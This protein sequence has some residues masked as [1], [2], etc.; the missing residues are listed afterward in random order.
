MTSPGSTAAQEFYGRWAGLYDL[1]ARRTP[2][3]AGLRRRAAAACRLEAGDT[4]VEMGCGTGANF[5]YIRDAVGPEGAVFGIDLVP[6]MLGEARRRIRKRGWENV[7]VARGD[8]TQ[9]PIGE[10]DAVVSTFLVGMLADPAS[11]VRNWIDHVEP[12]GRVAIMNARRSDRLVAAPL[13]LGFRL[14]VR[15]SLPSGKATRKS[16]VRELETRWE[17]ARDA[18]LEGTVD[19]ETDELGL[20]FIPIA[21]GRVP[22]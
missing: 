7:H 3:I 13:N 9:P 1:L 12:G 18:V 19:H 15:L 22:T 10:V 8:A 2:G 4:V 14:F 6:E 21:S 11:A 20:G 16:P 5:P 17:A